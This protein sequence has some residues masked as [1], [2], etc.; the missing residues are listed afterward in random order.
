M[1]LNSSTRGRIYKKLLPSGIGSSIYAYSNE[2]R[3]LKTLVPLGMGSRIR[4]FHGDRILKRPLPCF[5]RKD[6]IYAWSKGDKME[7]RC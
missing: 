1:L 2:D 3:I 6:L 5:T 4:E 7:H